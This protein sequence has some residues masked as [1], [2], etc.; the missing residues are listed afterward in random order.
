MGARKE[1]SAWSGG[2]QK[3]GA[4]KWDAGER[5]AARTGGIGQAVG[6]DRLENKMLSPRTTRSTGITRV[7]AA[8]TLLLDATRYERASNRLRGS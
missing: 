2:A 1:G 4:Q 7:R 5:S 8:R 3:C 6:L